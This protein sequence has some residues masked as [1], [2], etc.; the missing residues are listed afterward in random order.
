MRRLRHS[1]RKTVPRRLSIFHERHNHSV[2]SLLGILLHHKRQIF[3]SGGENIKNRD[4][5]NR[6][7]LHFVAGL[8][9]SFLHNTCGSLVFFFKK[10]LDCYL[11][12]VTF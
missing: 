2:G 9:D 11:A 8:L 12:L 4:N 3:A 10:I 6:H 7:I 5:W 1:Y